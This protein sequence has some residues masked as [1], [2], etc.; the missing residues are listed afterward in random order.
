MA[1][2]NGKPITQSEHRDA[3]LFL[4][5]R[6]FGEKIPRLSEKDETAVT[7]TALRE[8]VRY[9]LIV[10]E[11]ATLG[12]KADPEEIDNYLA[13]RPLTRRPGTQAGHGVTLGQHAVVLAKQVDKDGVVLR[14]RP[15]C[16][17]VERQWQ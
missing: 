6:Q 2:V 5:H 7:E 11:A 12:V 9:R 17:P 3:A 4:L 13:R 14:D 1:V 8:L 16:L 15:Q 10:D